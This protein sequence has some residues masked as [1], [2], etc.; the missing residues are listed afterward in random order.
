MLTKDGY[1]KIVNQIQGFSENSLDLEEVIEK[2]IELLSGSQVKEAEVS[3]YLSEIDES[4][5]D[6]MFQD[7]TARGLA[8]YFDGLENINDIIRYFLRYEVELIQT[9]SAFYFIQQV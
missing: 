9:E 2:T 6:E 8:S 4:E 5:T 3:E 7:S 1:N